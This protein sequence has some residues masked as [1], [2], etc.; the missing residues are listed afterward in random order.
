MFY[1][2]MFEQLTKL[3]IMEVQVRHVF[4]C[5]FFYS[6]ITSLDPLPH[7]LAKQNILTSFR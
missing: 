1:N 7:Q 6:I 2:L 4:L 3:R 5:F